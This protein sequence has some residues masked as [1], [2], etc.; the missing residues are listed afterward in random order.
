MLIFIQDTK[1]CL[2]K[3]ICHPRE[4]D[5][6]IYLLGMSE[7]PLF[8]EILGYQY[9]FPVS[10]SLVHETLLLMLH[11]FEL[12]ILGRDNKIKLQIVTTLI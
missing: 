11:G 7:Y 2:M 10:I 12:M 9:F 3:I 5:R 6:I 4:I 1:S 8:S